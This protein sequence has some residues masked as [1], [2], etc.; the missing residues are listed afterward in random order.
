[1]KT[2]LHGNISK[3]PSNVFGFVFSNTAHLGKHEFVLAFANRVC[4]P[5]HIHKRYLAHRVGKVAIYLLLENFSISISQWLHRAMISLN[6]PGSDLMAHTIANKLGYNWSKYRLVACLAPSHHH[7]QYG[8]FVNYTLMMINKT[9]RFYWK[10]ADFCPKTCLQ[11]G[12]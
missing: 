10:Y 2:I 8:I 9:I 6:S 11:N 12:V 7:K 1:M 3:A 4:C 5:I